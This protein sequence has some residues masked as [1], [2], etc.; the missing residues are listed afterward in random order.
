MSIPVT[1]R[2]D[3]DAVRLRQL[4]RRSKD[5]PQTRRLLALAVIYEGG[6]RTQA[7]EIGGKGGRFPT[8]ACDLG[9]EIQG[10]GRGG[11]I[12]DANPPAPFGEIEGDAFA[13]PA[14]RA[15]HE[16]DAGLLVL[17]HAVFVGACET[18]RQANFCA[19]ARRSERTERAGDVV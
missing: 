4:A 10:L 18:N 5:A 12:M 17:S 6:S 19:T 16:H 14:R 2:S 15:G 1:L 11:M 8:F 7:A 9:D 3:Y 13:K